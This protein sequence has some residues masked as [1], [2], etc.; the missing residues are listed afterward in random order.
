MLHRRAESVLDDLA[1]DVLVSDSAG[2]A[3]NQLA[4]DVSEEPPDLTP[5]IPPNDIDNESETSAAAEPEE[6]DETAAETVEA[7]E[8]VIDPPQ[9]L[10]VSPDIEEMA[11][12]GD[13]MA[14]ELKEFD[15]YIRH[16][17]VDEARLVL[18][19]LPEHYKEHPH[20]LERLSRL[21]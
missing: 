3:E 20:V 17:L 5:S 2:S 7:T 14:G 6:T 16:G 21:N 13:E 11:P 12:I 4:D 10:A 15:F 1:S 8:T 18:D 9:D 19:E